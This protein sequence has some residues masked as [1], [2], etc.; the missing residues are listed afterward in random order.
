MNETKEISADELSKYAHSYQG[1]V[2]NHGCILE[3][4]RGNVVFDLSSISNIDKCKIYLKKISGNGKVIVNVGSNVAECIIGSKISQTIDVHLNSEKLF[5]IYRPN[6]SLGE[7][8]IVGILVEGESIQESELVANWKSLINKC[9]SYSCIRLLENKLFASGGG[10]IENEYLI[11]HLETNP[12]GMFKREN[13]K[14]I[15]LG[16]CEV[17]SLAIDVN[18]ELK[19]PASTNFI[20][21]RERPGPDIY[22]RPP[23]SIDTIKIN[24]P[25]LNLP[26]TVLPQKVLDSAIIYDS[27]RSRGLEAIKSSAN[28]AVK[29]IVSNNQEYLVLR[30]TGICNINIENLQPNTEYVVVINAKKLSGNGKFHIGF[31]PD[32]KP[33]V[34][35]ITVIIDGGDESEKYLTINT[36]KAPDKG[37]MYKLHFAMNDDGLGEVLISRIRITAGI[38]LEHVRYG[39]EKG[40]EINPAITQMVSLAVNY[41]TNVDNT[42]NDTVFQTSKRYARQ[43]SSVY[44]AQHL[45]QIGGGIISSTFSGLAWI[46]KI[47][48][49]FPNLQIYKYKDN[50]SPVKTL[51]I[52]K[53]G[54]L[55][56]ADRI[57]I[58]A[59]KEEQIT[60]NDL[61]ILSLAKLIATPSL[62]NM[63][64]LDSRCQNSS[65]I[66]LFKPLPMVRP[67]EVP[68]LKQK[69][70]IVVF[71]RNTETTQR[72]LDAHT[73]SDPPIVLIGGRGKFADFVIP[74]NEYLSY[75]KLMYIIFGARCIIDVPTHNDYISG[76]LHLGQAAGVPIV[77]SN[78]FVMDKENCVF[79]LPDEVKENIKLPAVDLLKEAIRKGLEL[80]NMH[81][82]VSNYNQHL[83]GAMSMIMNAG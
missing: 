80:K 42:Y 39:I 64:F 7:I 17:T 25:I 45:S 32:N 22:V 5:K 8:A 16:T 72:I 75:E 82:D 33:P 61:E 52:G 28:K 59:F 4:K 21:H 9:G 11:T 54:A 34:Q 18:A 43:V 55:I 73:E 26:Q 66:H 36:N 63:Q 81:R 20:M 24:Y 79:V 13:N 29:Y 15:F 48:T 40:Y 53:I 10:F 78:W 31:T 2:F 56:P 70:Y 76:F 60:D 41:S 6:D 71:N 19:K 69:D 68:F 67:L 47:A 49:F 77:S 3:S 12:P 37:E 57:W 83:L 51:S 35:N 62:P 50:V 46:N 1:A 38:S 74:V 58:D 44:S 14:I 23:S 65:V 30:R 27:R